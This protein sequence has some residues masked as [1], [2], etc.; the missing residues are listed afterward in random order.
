MS[1]SSTTTDADLIEPMH[2][3]QVAK[4]FG[5]SAAITPLDVA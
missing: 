2:P 4:H 3:G 5:A 1:N